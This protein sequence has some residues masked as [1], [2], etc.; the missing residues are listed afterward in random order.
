MKYYD[1]GSRYMFELQA[2]FSESNENSVDPFTRSLLSTDFADK[3]IRIRP[4][5][6][7]GFVNLKRLY[8]SW[9]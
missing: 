1:T 8:G 7:K 3:K 2:Y 4:D 6:A 5:N 9:I